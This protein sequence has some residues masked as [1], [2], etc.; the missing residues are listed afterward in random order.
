LLR[1]GFREA[2]EAGLKSNELADLAQEILREK[3]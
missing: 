1:A 3:K 2:A